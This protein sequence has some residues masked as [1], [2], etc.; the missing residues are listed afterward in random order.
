MALYNLTNATTPDGILIG[1]ASSVPA[2]PIMIL[3]FSWFFVFLGG[4][5]RQNA[6]YGY[7]DASQWAV[8]ASMA[9]M[10]L[11]LVMTTTEGLIAPLVLGINVGLVILTAIWFFM[12]KGRIE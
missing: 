1:T 7:A 12:S 11:S 8:L 3:V 9:T 2:F 5:A 4:S 10:L 6:R